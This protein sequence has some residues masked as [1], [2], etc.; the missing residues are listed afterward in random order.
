MDFLPREQI[1]N[2]LQKPLQSYIVQFGIEDI[3]I[4][5]EESQEELKRPS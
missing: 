2:D 4:F 3:G 5:E 1:M